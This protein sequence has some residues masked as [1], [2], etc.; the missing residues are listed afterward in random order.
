SWPNNSLSMV[1]SGIAPQ[2]TAI[3]G[4]CL[5]DERA[6]IILENA[7]LPTPLS[8]T[9]STDKSVLATCAAVLN[10]WLSA[11]ELPMIPNLF[12]MLCSSIFNYYSLPTLPDHLLSGKTL[13]TSCFKIGRYFLHIVHIVSSSIKS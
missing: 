2:L 8:P 11:A 5:R 7:S 13:A 10:A 3:K 9:I 6:C 12:L 1:P 4:L